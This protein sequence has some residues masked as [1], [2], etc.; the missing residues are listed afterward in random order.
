LEDRKAVDVASL[1]WFS[2]PG[3]QVLFRRHARLNLGDVRGR[4]ELAAN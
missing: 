3:P 1:E 2:E 4:V